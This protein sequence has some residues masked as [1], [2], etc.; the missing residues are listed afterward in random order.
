MKKGKKM[1]GSLKYLSYLCNQKD[2]ENEF[3]HSII[4]NVAN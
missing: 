1:F 2:E 3:R 4:N